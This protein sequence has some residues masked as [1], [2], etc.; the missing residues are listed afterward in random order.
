MHNRLLQAASP[1]PCM[2]SW[3]R[4]GG[5]THEDRLQNKALFRKDTQQGCCATA[6]STQG[7]TTTQ[8]LLQDNLLV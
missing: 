1:D 4:K 6:A 5:S 3:P 7:Q 2:K 8:Y